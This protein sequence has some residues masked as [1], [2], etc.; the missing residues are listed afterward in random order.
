VRAPANG[1]SPS[2]LF[3]GDTFTH[4]IEPEIEQAA[5][6]VLA[7]LGLDVRVI[8]SRGAGAALL[9]K[10]FVDPA[11]RHAKRVLEQLQKMDPEASLPVVGLEPPEVYCL[12][13]DLATCCRGERMRSPA[14]GEGCLDEYLIRRSA[15]KLGSRIVQGLQK[16]KFQYTPPACGPPSG[17][18]LPQALRL[19]S[20]Y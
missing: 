8:P 2:I 1:P 13:N 4:Y 9:S 14:R 19:R 18:G 7:S 6:D 10:G 3:L 11:R 15:G 12:K 20:P 5:F 16:V 17:D